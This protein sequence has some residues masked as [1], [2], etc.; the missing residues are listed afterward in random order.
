MTN[1]GTMFVIEYEHKYGTTYNSNKRK[2]GC[3]TSFKY[4]IS[5]GR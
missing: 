5:V 4:E 1:Y 3:H 2:L